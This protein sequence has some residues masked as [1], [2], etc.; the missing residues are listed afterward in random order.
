[1]KYSTL[2]SKLS[3][4]PTL[5]MAAKA[6]KLV[7]EGLDIISF[8]AG[9]PDFHTPAQVKAAGIAA[10]KKNITGYTASSG[11]PELRKHVARWMTR[12]VGVEYAPNQILVSSGAK[13]A[14]AA[15]ILA[16]VDPGD[17]V[18][19]PAPYWVSYPD[20]IKLAGA[21]PIPVETDL[22]HG[23]KMTPSALEASITPKTKM[24]LLNSPNNPTGAV[25][26]HTELIALAE[27]LARF[28]EVWILSDEIYSRLIF[29]GKKHRSIAA[30]S[31]NIAERTIIV[32]GVSKAFSMTGWRIGWA[33]GPKELIARAGKIQS[34]TTSCPSS[35]S[36]SAAEAALQ[37]DDSFMADW[38]EQYS[39]RRD[40][41]IDLLKA[42]PGIK[43]FVPD[44]AFY[45]FCDIRQWIGKTKPKGGK[46][47]SCFD[48]AEYLLDEA[49]IAAVPGDAFGAEGYIRFSFACSEDDI[50]RGVPRI[51]EA[52][53]KLK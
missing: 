42:V 30:I 49:M 53:G 39:R 25:Y 1:M 48:A 35:I 12:E 43:P 29:D 44:G 51:A 16:T 3:D 14:I 19:F 9:E 5:A 41:F 2:S 7:S 23:F 36:Q 15:A 17:E 33:A 31:S 37:M 4:S 34:H 38:V 40:I 8:S 27:V 6:K 50:R 46:L 10:I 45:L 24:V 18:I 52:A 28:P 47:S 22:A 20:M 26:S 13:F 11:T 21:E 32:N